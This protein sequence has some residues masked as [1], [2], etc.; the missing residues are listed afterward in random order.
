MPGRRRGLIA[1]RIPIWQGRGRHEISLGLVEMQVAASIPDPTC[2]IVLRLGTKGVL[3][4]QVTIGN[5]TKTV[6]I[7]VEVGPSRRQRTRPWKFVSLGPDTGPPVH[8]AGPSLPANP[9]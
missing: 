9:R 4:V 7:Y 5:R 1:F 8:P 2:R 3:R 6:S